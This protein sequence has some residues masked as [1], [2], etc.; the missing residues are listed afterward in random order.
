M[1]ESDNGL[2]A[3]IDS[4]VN[5]SSVASSLPRISLVSKP[6]GG[7][8]QEGSP[9]KKRQPSVRRLKSK[10]SSNNRTPILKIENSLEREVELGDMNSNRHKSPQ[11]INY[12]HSPASL[13][14]LKAN[15]GVA[16]L[17]PGLGR[18]Q[19]LLIQTATLST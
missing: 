9:L 6:S 11:S 3:S 19:S 1:S 8:L 2:L 12:D 13:R 15:S 7:R 18:N 5:V 14:N 17:T 16:G 4:S 10:R